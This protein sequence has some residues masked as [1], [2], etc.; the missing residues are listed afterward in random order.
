MGEQKVR[1]VYLHN[2]ENTLVERNQITARLY[3]ISQTTSVIRIMSAIKYL[4]AKTIYIPRNRRTNRRRGFAV[5]GFGSQ[6]EL[7]KALSSHVELFGS[8]T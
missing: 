2:W 8:K 3:G 1:I 4:K 5:V 6:K 7:Q